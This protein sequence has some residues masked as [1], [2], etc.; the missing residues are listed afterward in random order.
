VQLRVFEWEVVDEGE[1]MSK[2]RRVSSLL[3]K[4][5]ENIFPVQTLSKCR[6]P[7]GFRETWGRHVGL[8]YSGS[9]SHV[10]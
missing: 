2:E 3:K 6:G 10:L 4:T 1:E 9:T 5:K 7:P 8:G